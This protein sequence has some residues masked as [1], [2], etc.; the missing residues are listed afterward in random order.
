[1]M[2]FRW[3]FQLVWWWRRWSFG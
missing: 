3:R 2:Y 1:M